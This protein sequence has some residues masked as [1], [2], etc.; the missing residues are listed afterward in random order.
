[1]NTDFYG[2]PLSRTNQ[3]RILTARKWLQRSAISLVVVLSVLGTLAFYR[4]YLNPPSIDVEAIAQRTTNEHDQIGGFAADFVG[5]WLTTTADD[6]TAMIDYIDTKTAGVAPPH[7]TAA[8]SQATTRK[9]SVI[10]TGTVGSVDMFSATV[11][12]LERQIPSA[13]PRRKYYRVP[14]SM[15][16]QQTKVMGWPV[17]VNGP[18]PGVHVK[19]DFPVTVDQ[20]AKLYMLVSDFVSTYLTKTTGLDRYVVA[21]S[22]VWPVGGYS[23]ARLTS[24]QLSRELPEKPAPGQ[25]ISALAGVQAAT[26]Q[27]VPLPMTIPL[28]LENNNG[29]WMI[30]ALDLTPALSTDPPEPL[31]PDK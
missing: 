16:R 25:A 20:G 28:T 27:Q 30:S 3:S 7:K 21:G 12:A 23:S 15:W 19:L 13:A 1:V 8:A 11:T 31:N 14:V 2:V 29:T 24:L 26:S 5:L 4:S 10:Y 18:G 9:V 17:P 22:D 6:A